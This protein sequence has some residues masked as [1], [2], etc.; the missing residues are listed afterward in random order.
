MNKTGSVALAIAAGL[1]LGSTLTLSFTSSAQQS[2][3]LSRIEK[4]AD[5]WEIQN[6]V[7]RYS[8]YVIAN[9]WIEVGN[10]FALDDPEVYQSVPWEMRGAEV[11]KYFT[12]RA[13]QELEPGVMH[14]HSFLAPLIEVANDGQT[15]QG[16]WDSIGMD[17]GSGNAMGNWGWV[18]YN[19][20]FK[21]V[22][23]EWKIWHLQVKTIWRA[24]YGE[25]WAQMVQQATKGEFTGGGEA[26]AYYTAPAE[27]TAPGPGS[28][29]PAQQNTRWR[30]SGA[31][32]TPQIPDYV[33]APFET[34][35]PANAYIGR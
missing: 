30:Y 34:F 19:I 13:A 26:G 28:S 14:Q 23:N 10:L 17:A 31:D 16:S 5:A 7:G 8:I 25:A 12:D 32:D 6:I 18:R 11:R 21:K 33:P 29:A 9:Q 15:A 20:D 3:S 24:P 27:T 2:P 22:D 1:I 35:D 4:A